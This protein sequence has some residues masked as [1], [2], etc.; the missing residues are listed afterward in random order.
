MKRRGGW[1]VLV[2]L[3][4]TVG[5]ALGWQRWQTTLLRISLDPLREQ[6][7]DLETVRTENVRLKAGRMPA[8]EVERLRMEGEEWRRLRAEREALAARAGK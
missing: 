5:A 1:I 6:A 7:R 8:A 2:L 3:T 4:A